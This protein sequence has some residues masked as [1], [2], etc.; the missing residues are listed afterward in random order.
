MM[1]PPR[2]MG[3]TNDTASEDSQPLSAGWELALLPAGVATD[4]VALASVLA[5][6]LAVAP[7]AWTA[8]PVPGTAMAALFAAG[9]ADFTR[10]PDLDSQDVWYRCR[11]PASGTDATAATELVFE[12]LATLAQVWLNGEALLTSDNMF[13]AHAVDVSGRLRPDNELLIRFA[14]VQQALKARRP[15]PRWRTRL[16]E[17]QQLRWIRASLLGRIPGWSPAVPAIG[18]W[19]PVQ[20]RTRQAIAWETCD[21]RSRLDSSTGVVSVNARLRALAPELAVRAVR[22]SVGDAQV[23]LRLQA[24]AGGVWQAEGELHLPGVARWWPHTHG[25]PAL[26]AV[27]LTVETDRST[28]ERKLGR[29]GFRHIALDSTGD[30]FAIAV[31]GVPVFCRG[32]CWTTTDVLNLAGTEAAAREALLLAQE[33]GMNMLRVGGTMFYEAD[34]FYALCDELGILLWHDFMFANMDYPADDPAF[35]ASV[36]AEARQFL[37]RTQL[38]PSIAL[39]CGNSEVEQQAAMLGLDKALWRSP[40]FGERLPALVAELRPDVPYWPSSPAGGVLPF[41]VDSGA[42]HYFGVG[43]YQQ[44]LTD[45]RRSGVRFTSECLA[46]ANVP[47]PETIESFMGEGQ[48]PPT[49]PLWKARVPR[50]SGPGWD[51]DDVRDHY[52]REL[53]QLD[54]VRLRYADAGRY[55]ALGRV[56]S[57]EVMAA[58]FGEWRRHGSSCAGG[59]VWFL[60]DLWAGAGWGVIDARG[61]PKAA[62]HYLQRALAPV[63]LFITNEGVN[64]LALHAVNDRPQAIEARLSL[65]LYRHGEKAVAEGAQA[66]QIPAHGSVQVRGDALFGHFTDSSYTYRFGPTGHDVAHAVLRDTATGAVLGQDFFFPLGHGFAVQPVLGLQATVQAADADGYDVTVGCP[67]FAQAVHLDVPGWRASHNHFHLAPGGSQTVRLSARTPG[68]R[69]RGTL[70]ALN[71]HETLTLAPVAA[72]NPA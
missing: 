66:V 53:F 9:Q 39:L 61:V 70:R 63:A 58:A 11:F 72:D 62:W 45:A 55:L 27:A 59:I 37:A 52:V 40:L 21:V 4:P 17:Q 31:N 57:G 46:F 5:N 35:A 13:L 26:H 68:A 56:A 20:L 14:S 1:P 30:N 67:R 54:P 24:L 48:V 6:A 2:G 15:R 12:G 22:L 18:P 47:E 3:G 16:V 42:A 33:A 60:R 28:L 49:H 7:A 65:T 25:E 43:A 38:S 19:R 8:A 23:P 71:G 34:H 10:L 44:P 51:F 50:D 32:A 29:T 64:G 41:Q 36:G 69:L